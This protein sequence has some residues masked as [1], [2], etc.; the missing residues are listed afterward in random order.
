MV[1]YIATK[2]GAQE[3]PR[4]GAQNLK[5]AAKLL[6]LAPKTDSSS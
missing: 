4:A 2:R 1:A 5:F 6:L 3:P